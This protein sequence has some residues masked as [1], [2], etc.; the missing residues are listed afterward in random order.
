MKVRMASIHGY[1]ILS[2]S[3]PTQRSFKEPAVHYL[4]C[5]RHEPKVPGPDD[6]RTLFVVNV[7]SDATEAHFQKLFTS[8]G[9]G[10]VELVKFEGARSISKPAIAPAEQPKSKGKKKRKRDDVQ[11]EAGELPEVWDRQLHRSGGTGLVVFVD[12]AALDA[13]MKAIF[14][15]GRKTVVKWGEQAE[16]KASGLGSHRMN[17]RV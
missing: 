11:K 7:P 12:K 17:P 1:M 15:R 14:K 10:R 8:L 3:L 5:R 13:S 6:D 2:L 4:Y 16:D 9:G